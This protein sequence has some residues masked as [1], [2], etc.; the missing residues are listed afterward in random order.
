ML[1]YLVVSGPHAKEAGALL[2][3][4]DGLAL[5]KLLDEPI[6]CLGGHLGGHIAVERGGAAA[7]LHVAQY[8]LARGEDAFTL[9]RVQ[10]KN[11]E[12]LSWSQK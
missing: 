6:V 12:V 1:S 10:A 8:I 3:V 4:S 5:L 7:L 9:L 11:K 2:R